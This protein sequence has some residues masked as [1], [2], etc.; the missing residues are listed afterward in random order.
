[1]SRKH[2]YILRIF[3]FRS[4]SVAKCIVFIIS[5]YSHDAISKM[6]WLEFRFQNL[7]FSKSAGKNVPFS[8]ER[9]ANPSHF[10]PFSK[11]VGIL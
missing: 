6:C 5:E 10:S 9:E 2:T 4:K 7:P 11:C 3:Q 8:Y 1:M